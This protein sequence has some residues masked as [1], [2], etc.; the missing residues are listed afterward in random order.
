[1]YFRVGKARRAFRQTNELRS[2][3][4]LVCSVF[5]HSLS[6]FLFAFCFAL[7]GQR[8]KDKRLFRSCLLSTPLGRRAAMLLEHDTSKKQSSVRKC[9]REVVPS[10]VPIKS[11]ARPDRRRC[12]ENALVESSRGTGNLIFYVPFR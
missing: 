12:D 6:L 4:L 7:G 9:T 2:F 1:M 10:A 11:L 8:K 5:L 3:R